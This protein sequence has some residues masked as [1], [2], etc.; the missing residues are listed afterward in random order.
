MMLRGVSILIL[1]AAALTA[2]IAVAQP[3]AQG[4]HHGGH[5]AALDHNGDGYLDKN[6]VSGKLAEN[7]DKLDTDHDGKLSRDELRA[8]WKAHRDHDAHHM[9]L[10]KLDADHDGR[11]SLAEF[12]TSMK[13]RF[14]HLDANHD[15][16]ID[17]AEL[18]ARHKH[19]DD[20]SW[21][22][23]GSSP[24]FEGTAPKQ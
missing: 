5:F 21:G 11:I 16:Y 4:A 9:G 3:T 6:E 20:G 12:T 14:D 15:G 13:A 19:G 23:P 24:P 22:R 18:A 8:A 1:A 7:F 17:N 10:S 2:G